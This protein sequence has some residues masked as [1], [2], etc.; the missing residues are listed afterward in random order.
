MLR[1]EGESRREGGREGGREG[2]SVKRLKRRVYP[3]D[4]IENWGKLKL[5]TILGTQLHLGMCRKSLQT[6]TEAR[7]LCCHGR[8][9]GML[10]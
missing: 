6:I 2:D 5:A 1:D 7:G 4:H 8:S 3:L 9:K 10:I